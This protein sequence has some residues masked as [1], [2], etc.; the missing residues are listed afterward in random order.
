MVQTDNI[1]G[2]QR[3]RVNYLQLI[4]PMVAILQKHE[5][6]MQAQERKITEQDKRLNQLETQVQELLNMVKQLQRNS[7]N[8]LPISIE[9]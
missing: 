8:N 2:K 1:E 5:R 7:T 6:K 3:M 9:H 4:S